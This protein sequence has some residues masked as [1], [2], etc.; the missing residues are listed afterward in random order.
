[1]CM[2]CNLC[3]SHG[4]LIRRFLQLHFTS[5]KCQSFSRH[6]RRSGLRT[7]GRRLAENESRDRVTQVRCSGTDSPRQTPRC[8]Q[9]QTDHKHDSRR[10]VQGASETDRRDTEEA[11]Y[12]SAALRRL[13]RAQNWCDSCPHLCDHLVTQHLRNVIRLAIAESIAF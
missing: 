11:R 10:F 1:M 8:V 13:I 5:W 6:E 7:N 9:K 4:D 2:H 12:L 3:V